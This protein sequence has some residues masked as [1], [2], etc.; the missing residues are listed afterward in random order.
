MLI[1]VAFTALLIVIQPQVAREI[2]TQ[3][4][5]GMATELQL[6]A[7]LQLTLWQQYVNPGLFSNVA[8]LMQ[9]L[10][11]F[12][13]IAMVWYAIRPKVVPVCRKLAASCERRQKS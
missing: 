6:L 13:S 2:L 12:L 3:S 9:G 11:G 10:F 8:I 5:L 4:L 7:L 1:D